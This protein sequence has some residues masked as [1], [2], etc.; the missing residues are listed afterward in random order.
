[1]AGETHASAQ[2]PAEGG[3]YYHGVAHDE[4]PFPLHTA[5]RNG[6]D[7]KLRAL[8]ASGRVAVDVMNEFGTTALHHA[9]GGGHLGC[10]REL[11][12]L[13]ADVD[14][15]DKTGCTPLQVA[16]LV[17]KEDIVGLLLAQGADISKADD[18]GHTPLSIAQ[19]GDHLAVLSLLESA[20]V[21]GYVRAGGSAAVA[22]EEVEL[23]RDISA[24][25]M[26]RMEEEIARSKAERAAGPQPP[27]VGRHS[28]PFAEEGLQSV[29]YMAA[30]LQAQ[31]MGLAK[32]LIQIEAAK[33]REAAL[34]EL[35]EHEGGPSDA[36]LLAQ[37]ADLDAEL[38]LRA[39]HEVG[40]V[41]GAVD[42]QAEHARIGWSAA[43]EGQRI[44]AQRA[45]ADEAEV[46]LT[47][48]E[49]MHSAAA[50]GSEQDLM[51]LVEGGA[52]VDIPDDYLRTPL[53]VAAMYGHLNCVE[54]LLENNA[55]PNNTDYLSSMDGEGCSALAQASMH[56]RDDV[57][58]MLLAHSADT[59][60]ADAFGC[61][62]LQIAAQHG[63]DTAIK[64]LLDHNADV[65]ARDKRGWTA[66]HRA[67]AAGDVNVVERLLGHSVN[68]SM[69]DNDGKTAYHRA[70]EGRHIKVMGLLHQEE[71]ESSAEQTMR[72]VGTEQ[73]VREH[74]VQDYSELAAPAPEP[75]AAAPPTAVLA[76]SVE[77]RNDVQAELMRMRDHQLARMADE[78]ELIRLQKQELEELKERALQESAEL[79]AQQKAAE[80]SKKEAELAA[81]D[82]AAQAA[83]ATGQAQRA[84]AAPLN[85]M[86]H[87][88]GQSDAVMRGREDAARL[89]VDY[90]AQRQAVVD[91]ALSRKMAMAQNVG[92]ME[93]WGDYGNG[94]F[95]VLAAPENSNDDINVQRSR[96]PGPAVQAASARDSSYA[97]AENAGD[98][99]DWAEGPYGYRWEL[100]DAGR[101][102]LM[103]GSGLE[104]LSYSSAFHVNEAPRYEEVQVLPEHMRPGGGRNSA[105]HASTTKKV[106]VLERSLAFSSEELS[107]YEDTTARALEAAGVPEDRAK[108]A[109]KQATDNAKVV[110]EKKQAWDQLEQDA[111]QEQK[112]QQQ[113]PRRVSTITTDRPV[114]PPRPQITPPQELLSYE[115]PQGGVP[116]VAKKKPA[117]KPSK[118]LAG[119]GADFQPYDPKQKFGPIGGDK[120]MSVEALERAR[121]GNGKAPR[122]FS[123]EE[124]ED[125]RRRNGPGKMT[126][127]AMLAA[128]RAAE[129]EEHIMQAGKFKAKPVPLSVRAPPQAGQKTGPISMQAKLKQ[130]EMKRRQQAA[131]HAKAMEVKMRAAEIKQTGTAAKPFN[132]VEWSVKSFVGKLGIVFGDQ[133]PY[134]KKIH[135]R[136]PGE[137]VPGLT[138]DCK[139]Q[140]IE[141]PRESH[142]DKGNPC[143]VMVHE[144]CHGMTYEEAKVR[145]G[146]RPLKLSFTK[147]G[148]RAKPVPKACDLDSVGKLDEMA[149]VDEERKRMNREKAKENFRKVQAPQ[150][151]PRSGS[152]KAKMQESIDRRHAAAT[153][154]DEAAGGNKESGFDARWN[155]WMR[156]E[157]LV[158]DDATSGPPRRLNHTALLSMRQLQRACR[159][160]AGLPPL[161][162]AEM[163]GALDEMKAD[164]MTPHSN[165]DTACVTTDQ[166]KKWVRQQQHIMCWGRVQ[167]SATG[168]LEQSRAVKVL[169]DILADEYR[170]P[171]TRWPNLGSRAPQ[172]RS[173]FV[174]DRPK[175]VF[176][177]NQEKFQREVD[178]HMTD[179]ELMELS[180]AQ[181]EMTV[182]VMDVARTGHRW[183][184]EVDDAIAVAAAGLPPPLVLGT[185]D[186]VGGAPAAEELDEASAMQA[187]DGR[188]YQ[189]EE[190]PLPS[191][192]IVAATA[193]AEMVA[194]QERTEEYVQ[195]H[196][197]TAPQPEKAYPGGIVTWKDLATDS[198]PTAT[199][200]QAPVTSSSAA[201]L[202]A[203]MN[204]SYSAGQ[205]QAKE[206]KRNL[207]SLPAEKYTEWKNAKDLQKEELLA[208]E[209]QAARKR[210]ARSQQKME[211]ARLASQ[212]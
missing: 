50:S 57:V 46:E 14:R 52:Y 123:F 162:D 150:L 135:A 6:N 61:T 154:A 9:T 182:K 30:Q 128:E 79:L 179:E 103:G 88:F 138:V 125:E 1:M 116:A 117:K 35:A 137:S 43:E 39:D 77:S 11:L 83:I 159:K 134:V 60:L 163:E 73:G 133:Y 201:A 32:E 142:D 145:L 8:V 55:N 139:L 51:Y 45:E 173:T 71:Y 168:G 118:F 172:P 23:S 74:A 143:T 89:A 186:F 158:F 98:G 156:H 5:A 54:R 18:A 136:S 140:S 157:G 62:P 59:E 27:P 193:A 189:D 4:D 25:E 69:V 211:L 67:A 115:Q 203:T 17:G 161:T 81:A 198:L 104:G 48:R 178:M 86:P 94:M 58:K 34:H 97:A 101:S 167:A 146:M 64:L 49:R 111:T 100:S 164:D 26:A 112:R 28:G 176:E 148:W 38:A 99:E 87:S 95:G 119:P 106:G 13:G 72:A 33:N 205:Y 16:T 37:L 92:S 188:V 187:L 194:T 160:V 124:R 36:Q 110:D 212:P 181:A 15:S 40:D 82:A 24:A 147:A 210:A 68:Q 12:S 208:L 93:M 165:P 75:E 78:R 149:A 132:L 175:I 85:N 126:Q 191:P 96:Q 108:Q 84:A 47:Q 56:G 155:S 190:E 114:P 7:A 122:P 107:E 171:E 42:A 109:A 65:N 184:Q 113:Q 3:P 10:V 91:S 144:T 166:A 102:L 153:V 169:A 105:V 195:Q 207:T 192:N 177:T 21:H 19:S 41:G 199:Q 29:E 127:G 2:S 121:C 200:E 120:P 209:A 90:V 63:R 66:L 130:D 44:I 76:H 152:R 196:A 131:K 70:K 31:K 53:Q 22:Q 80:Q 170:L 206:K 197:A 183:R 204:S 20:A 180:R 129:E 174:E 141:S 185:D 151:S 202:T